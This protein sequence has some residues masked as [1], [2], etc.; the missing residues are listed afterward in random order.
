MFSKDE[1]ND[2][3]LNLLEKAIYIVEKNKSNLG[4]V[5]KMSSLE[6]NRVALNLLSSVR[7]KDQHY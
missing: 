4:I 2:A 1:S 6:K 3:K 5:K 7:H